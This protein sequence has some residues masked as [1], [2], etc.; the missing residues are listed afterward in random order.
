MDRNDK[1]LSLL[2]KTLVAKIHWLRFFISI[3]WIRLVADTKADIDK[4]LK[5][6]LIYM[7]ILYDFLYPQFC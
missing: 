6:I 3:W 7:M 5:Q 1:Y 2:V 4:P